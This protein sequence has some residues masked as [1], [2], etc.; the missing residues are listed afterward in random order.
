MDIRN[1]LLI[2]WRVNIAIIYLLE[3]AAPWIVEIIDNLWITLW[4]IRS[5]EKFLWFP[6][7]IV[8]AWHFLF[9]IIL[10]ILFYQIKD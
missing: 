8:D 10:S 2:S 4:Y 7:E 3:S 9:Y 6:K 5:S 1:L